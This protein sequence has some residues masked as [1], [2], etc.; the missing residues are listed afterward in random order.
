[1]V[2]I[3]EV[4]VFDI[5]SSK[6]CD[7]SVKQYSGY[8]DISSDEH[9]FFWFFESR[10]K[11]NPLPSESIPLTIWLN[12]GPGCSSMIGLFQE[13]GPCNTIN[14]GA[15]TQW[16]PNSWNEVSH[17]L[18]IDQPVG[19][20]FS[21]GDSSKVSTSQQAADKLYVFLQ[22]FFK[23]FPEYAKLDL[24]FFGESFGGHYVPTSARVIYDN[25]QQ[26]IAGRGNG[27]IINLKTIGIGNGWINPLI[28]YATYA[29]FACDNVTACYKSQKNCAAVD[30]R[31]CDPIIRLYIY[32][33]DLSI[34]DIKEYSDPPTDYV[35]YLNQPDIIKQIGAKEKF[36]VCS[37]PIY[38][39]FQDSG[40]VISNTANHIEYLLDK[41]IPILLYHGDLD[42]ICNWYGG[43]DVA[44][45]LNWSH[46]DQFR[47]APTHEWSVSGKKAGTYQEASNLRFVRVYNAGHEVPYYQPENSLSSNGK[48]I[49]DIFKKKVQ[50]L[51]E[52]KEQNKKVGQIAYLE[53]GGRYIFYVITKEKYFQKPSKANF[54]RVLNELRVMCEEMNIRNLSMPRIGTGLDKLPLE[55]VHDVINATFQGTNMRILM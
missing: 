36:D 18:F 55:Y 20:G 52:L 26:I 46:A 22:N 24:H 48:R 17:M 13:L 33:T 39:A 29:S 11:K 41:N 25:N 38:F 44:L 40:D 6:L 42:F 37:D 49:A 47:K 10:N 4:G 8:L 16:N 14:K 1:P 51:Q 2:N 7:P 15:S 43:H 3:S 54:E 27:T 30:H 12:G 5:V 28:Q 19:V 9:I 21:D 31:W 35:N 53:R 45:N 34:Y 50:G 23:K 32:G